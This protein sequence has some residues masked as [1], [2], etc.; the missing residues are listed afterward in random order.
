LTAGERLVR[1]FYAELWNKW[2]LDVADQI[3]AEDLYFRGSLGSVERGREAFKAYVER[4]RAAFPDWH[5]RVDELFSA[6]DRVVARLTWTGTHR[7]E[8]AGVAPTGRSVAYLGVGLFTVSGSLITRAWI[9]GDTQELW[10]ALGRLD[11]Q[12][13]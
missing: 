4:V 7:G 12:P 13:P 6:G 1:R 5:N 10:R 9:V 3:L 11:R 8:L 2:R